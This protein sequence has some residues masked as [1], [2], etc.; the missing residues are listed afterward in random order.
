MKTFLDIVI[1]VI[2]PVLSH[3]QI[4]ELEHRAQ[5]G[6]SIKLGPSASYH[7]AIGLITVLEYI[8]FEEQTMTKFV[9]EIRRK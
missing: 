8:P 4:Q 2:Q 5:L 1:H 6:Q 9:Q 7:Y 3:H